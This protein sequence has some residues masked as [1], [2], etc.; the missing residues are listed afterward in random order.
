MVKNF[1]ILPLYVLLYTFYNTFKFACFYEKTLALRLQIEKF[2]SVFVNHFNFLKSPFTR[3]VAESWPQKG[4]E[5]EK[6]PPKIQL[7]ENYVDNHCSKYNAI[8]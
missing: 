4:Q 3:E 5:T 8:Y 1:L 2:P 7:G 6:L